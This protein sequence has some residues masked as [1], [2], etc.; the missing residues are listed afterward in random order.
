MDV[1][2]SCVAF[3]FAVAVMPQIFVEQSEL[4]ECCCCSVILN[5][6]AR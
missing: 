1:H 4:F 6:S 2:S 5:A 3:A